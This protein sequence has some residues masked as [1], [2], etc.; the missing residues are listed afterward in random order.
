MPPLRALTPTAAQQPLDERR[1]RRLSTDRFIPSRYATDLGVSAFEVE[2]GGGSTH[3][4]EANASPAKEEYKKRLAAEL[5][6]GGP[7]N[8]RVLNFGNR[9]ASDLP[10]ME[11]PACG[12][13]SLRML[14]TLNRQAVKRVSWTGRVIPQ[15]PERIL[16]APEL[17]DDYYLN[18]LD[19]NDSNILAVALGDSVYLW[20][21][22]S[23]AITPLISPQTSGSSGSHITSI[24][25]APRGQ[26]HMAVGTSDNKVQIWDTAKCRM[27]RSMDGHCG[28]VGVLAWNGSM[29]S[30]GSRDAS[31]IHRDARSPQHIFTRL[32]G[33]AGEVCGL[34]WAP[35]GVQL[36]S[37]GN[38]NMLNVW[39]ERRLTSAVPMYTFN[40]HKAAVKALAWSPWQKHVLASGGGTADCM[41]RFWNTSSGQFIN[42]VDTHSQVCALQWSQHDKE[43]VSSHGYCHNQLI[44]WKYP[45]M[46]KVAELTGHT[47]RV[48]HMAQSPDGTTIVSA[49]ADETLRFW[50][51]LGP[52]VGGRRSERESVLG[53]EAVA[54]SSASAWTI[55]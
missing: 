18:L 42:A 36:A 34:K 44:L 50:K 26:P 33:H 12:D 25:W 2:Q 5:F 22:T 17:L 6:R 13:D 52:D 4:G 30:S 49:A 31:I 45:S 43:L 8:N 20:N 41:I 9:P 15:S 16:D 23:G 32:E 35:H 53:A 21:A 1:A 54:G 14:Y 38:D 29:L 37:G 27:V 11:I 24:A 3:E 7:A 51:I 19:W 55:R 10:K 48:L 39:D 47:S 40:H 28:R 46:V